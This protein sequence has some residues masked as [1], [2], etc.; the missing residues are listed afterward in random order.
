M[1]RGHARANSKYIYRTKRCT[2]CIGSRIKEYITSVTENHFYLK[3]ILQKTEA[4]TSGAK[5]RCMCL[6]VGRARGLLGQV[7]HK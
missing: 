3:H 1:I 6:P 5:C 4:L 2:V 7:T